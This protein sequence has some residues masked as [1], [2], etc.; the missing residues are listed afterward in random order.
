M[1]RGNPLLAA[2]LGAVLATQSFEDNMDLFLCREV[3]LVARLISLTVS[4]A[5]SESRLVFVP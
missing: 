5:I 1:V 2:E 3:L 4:S